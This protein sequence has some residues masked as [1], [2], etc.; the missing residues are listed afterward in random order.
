MLLSVGCA[1]SPEVASAS[2]EVVASCAP[3]TAETV[4]VENAHGTL[5][6]T[7][8]L[9]ERCGRVPVV[10]LISGSGP[11]DREGNAPRSYGL[12]AEG[13][14]A[15]GIASLR[16]DDVGVG[17]S[18]TAVPSDPA[19]I[20]EIEYGFEVDAARRFLTVLRRDERLGPVVAAGHS[21]GA[22]TATL[23]AQEPDGADAVITLA[24][25]GR[26]I[27]VVLREQLA[28]T[29]EAEPLAR[30]DAALAK[31]RAGELAG[32]QEPP[33]DRILPPGVQRY[34]ISWIRHDPSA[35]L[36]QVA[37]PKLI[38]Q[39]G[40]DVQVTRE[41]ARL[42]AESSPDAQAVD[43]PDMCHTL[44]RAEIADIQAQQAQYSDPSLPLHEALVPAITAFVRSLA[45]GAGDRD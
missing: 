22:L 15:A 17:G 30:L 29:L 45:R 38:V 33:L 32:P 21:Q 35:E 11:Q 40:T 37:R 24:G 26:P 1:S 39:G 13:L 18:A 23:L 4:R 14:A 7:L 5:E 27:D 16:F 34:F 43:I 20:A 8:A 12:L 3:A 44:K 25:A 6:G 9:P 36:R 42:L 28:R 31:L 19:A 10:L 2:R 41:D